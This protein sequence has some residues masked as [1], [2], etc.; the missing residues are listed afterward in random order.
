MS[1]LAKIALP[2]VS[3]LSGFYGGG[4]L[5]NAL[6]GTLEGAG[7]GALAGAATGAAGAKAATKTT[8]P[9][10]PSPATMPSGPDDEAVKAARRRQI[11]E[12]QARSGRASTILS[13]SD[14][15]GG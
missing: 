11:A 3:I 14:A 7:A 5:G 9:V 4:A 8:T 2:A 6:F 12:I 10:I 1:K 13:Q 15:L